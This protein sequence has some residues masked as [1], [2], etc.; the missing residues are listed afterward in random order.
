MTLSYDP[1]GHQGL[2]QAFGQHQ[3]RGENKDHQCHAPG[4]ESGGEAA[5]HKISIAI[6]EGDLQVDSA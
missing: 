1:G 3:D 4:G 2:S 5:G 6:G